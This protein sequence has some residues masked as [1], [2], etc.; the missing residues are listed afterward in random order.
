MVDKN[1][2]GLLG[3]KLLRFL[4]EFNPDL[5]ELLLC[6]DVFN[7]LLSCFE[8]TPYTYPNHIVNHEKCN[9]NTIKVIC[10]AI[11]NKE[12]EIHDLFKM[13]FLERLKALYMNISDIVQGEE[14]LELVNIVF[15]KVF[16]KINLDDYSIDAV[17]KVLYFFQF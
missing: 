10:F 15:R 1:P 16:A 4:V 7:E 11:E 14:I 6:E 8:S 17:S 5:S 12:V 3:I 13:G 9:A 2:I